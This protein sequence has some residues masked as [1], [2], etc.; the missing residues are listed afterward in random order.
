STLFKSMKDHL[1]ILTK[2]DNTECVAWVESEDGS[3][4]VISISSEGA[5]I[6]SEG[7]LVFQ[8]NA[9]ISVE[10]LNTG[11]AYLV[12]Q[13]E[14]GAVTRKKFTV[15]EM[16]PGDTNQDA[17]VNLFDSYKIVDTDP[18]SLSELDKTAANFTGDN[19]VDQA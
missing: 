5:S 19:T 10:A 2:D 8:G 18:S 16:F 14:S 15:Q 11:E 9:E 6:D 13:D 7:R 3:S 12:V 17:E 1:E 4:D